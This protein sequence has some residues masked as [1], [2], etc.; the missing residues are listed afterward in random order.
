MRIPHKL[1]TSIP[2]GFMGVNVAIY[3]QNS[4][5]SSCIEWTIKIESCVSLRFCDRHLSLA[6]HHTKK[7]KML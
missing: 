3:S 2:Y 4:L 1:L 5:E 7:E 6:Y